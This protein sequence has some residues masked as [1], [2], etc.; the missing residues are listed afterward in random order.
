MDF[1]SPYDLQNENEESEKINKYLDL[2][3]ELKKAVKHYG[4]SENNWE[5]SFSERFL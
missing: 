4:E 2:S 1:A 5:Q 3:R